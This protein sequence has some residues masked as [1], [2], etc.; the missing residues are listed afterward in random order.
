MTAT[1]IHNH[2]NDDVRKLAF[3]IAGREDIDVPFVLEQIA[4]WQKACEKLPSWAQT[5]GII[6]PPHLSMEQCSGETAARIKADVAGRI[7]GCGTSDKASLLVDL[8]GG[9]GVDFS[10]MSRFFE[11]SIYVERNERLCETARNNFGVLA[12]DGA[13]VVCADGTEYLHNIEHASLIY[14]DPARRDACGGR[15]YAIGDCTPDV[16]CML[17]ELTEKADNVM[18]KLSPMLDWHDAVASLNAVY[19][20]VVREIHVV[21]VRNECKEL[22]F[23]LSRKSSSQPEIYCTNDGW[24][25]HCSLEE[26]CR[27][28]LTSDEPYTSLAGRYLYEPDASV[29]KAGCFGLLCNRYGVR[30]VGVNSRLFVSDRV[31]DDF[32]GRRFAVTAASSMNKKELKVALSGMAKAN[33]A[34]RN[35]PLT[36]SELRKRLRLGDGGDVYVFGTTCACGTRAVL[37]CSKI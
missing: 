5:D 24:I 36:V 8:T 23:V 29:M 31:V 7:C 11:R 14:L 26:A 22:L 15:T 2:R 35:F 37:V 25:V 32:P 1:F 16:L 19:P 28:T 10:F 33:V 12:L 13:D 18:L 3:Q 21:S 34:V 6:Y 9:F 30:Q 4:G 17:V 20:D 27:P